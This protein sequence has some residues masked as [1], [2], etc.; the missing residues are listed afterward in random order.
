MIATR[1]DT[2]SDHTS[3]FWGRF[4]EID[5]KDHQLVLCRLDPSVSI[6]SCWELVS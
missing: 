4:R 2:C 5:L 3:C 6:H 1:F